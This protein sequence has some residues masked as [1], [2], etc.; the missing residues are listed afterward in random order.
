[1][2]DLFGTKIM[3]ENVY[4]FTGEERYL[5][6]KELVRRKENFVA[7]FW[8]DSVF[9]FDL[10]EFNPSEI[11]QAI[12]ER[13]LFTTKKLIIIN[14]LPLVALAK[15]S[16]EKTEIIEKFTEEFVA[17]GWKIPEET[18][19]V[20]VNTKPDKR[21]RF[22]KFLEK[23]VKEVKEYNHCKPA[24]IKKFVTQELGWL[25]INSDTIEYLIGKIGWD[26]YRIRSECEKL[27]IRCEQK[28]IKKIDEKMIDNI[29][30]GHVALNAF[31]LIDNLLTNKKK[32]IQIVEKIKEDGSDRNQFA[33][34]IYRAL[35]LYIYL[36]DLYKQGFKDSKEIAK[37][38]FM[39]PWQVSQNMKNISQIMDHEKE[40]KNFYNK[41]MELDVDI[42]SWK[43]SDTYFWLGAKKLIY[44]L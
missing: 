28:K 19:I 10:E 6:D 32:A 41:L 9:L 24:E 31:T 26:L 7:K 27:K 12:Y 5:L 8:P 40:I 20:F 18:L 30:Y 39:N 11:K 37:I 35:K 21:L 15:L 44:S 2:K 33:G 3:L 43:L 1:L 22:Y 13:G 4:L 29:T 17:S 23:N 34:M 14:W 38:L 16:K 42:K 36:M 25:E